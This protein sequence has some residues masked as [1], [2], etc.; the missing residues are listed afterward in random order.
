M[1]EHSAVNRRVVGSSPTCG[2]KNLKK[3]RLGCL[4]FSLFRDGAAYVLGVC[5]TEYK[6]GTFYI[7]HTGNLVER[8]K[9]HNRTDCFEGHCTRKNGSWK[10]VWCEAHESRSSAMQREREIKR[11]KSAS[12]I[13]KPLLGKQDGC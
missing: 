6:R 7:G 13:R 4:P 8:L 12:W 5:L 3:G 9:D 11:M 2:A 10:L 1:A